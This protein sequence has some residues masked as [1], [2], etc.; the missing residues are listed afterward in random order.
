MRILLAGRGPKIVEISSW[1]ASKNRRLYVVTPDDLNP[2]QLPPHTRHIR[3]DPSTIDL[4]REGVPLDAD[5]VVIV[6][7]NDP[8]ALRACITNLRRQVRTPDMAV[9]SEAHQL[10][11]EFPELLFRS[12]ANIYRQEFHDLLKR[13]NTRKKFQQMQAI[14]RNASR[15]LIL[16]WGNPDPDSIASSFALQHLLQEDARQILIASMGDI[17][18]PEN[19]A[20]VEFLRIP[21]VKYEPSL[22][23]PGTAVFTVDAQPSFFSD[24]QITFDVVIDHHPK[25][26][27]AACRIKDVRPNYG[28]TATIL[29]E[30]FLHSRR[31]I[32]RR[33]ATALFYGLKTDT[34][35]LTRNVSEADIR[36]FR[37]L[38]KYADENLI[39][40]IELSQMP[41]AVLENFGVAIA[42]R[43][44]VGSFLFSY[45][46]PLD[47]ADI[48]VYIADFFMRLSGINAVA[49]GCRLPEKIVV[50][51]RSDGFR[52]DVGKVAE[53]TLQPY[54]TAGG[55]RT[56]ARAELPI[57]NVQTEVPDLND[58]AV[59]RWLIQKLAA[60]VKPLKRLL[61]QST[62]Q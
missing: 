13:V 48:A 24:G 21:M 45:L 62:P 2:A 32:P 46:G 56:M 52:T 43:K 9:I 25:G 59:E 5:D 33:V 38:K 23:I 36:A 53:T 44:V 37:I 58:A 17:T 20:M 31:K 28:S 49:V 47:N 1:L 16:L 55:H 39:R 35:N 41:M 8:Q 42:A 34:N 29:T 57:P 18:R 54:G 40:T 11:R 30:Y 15:V 51:F 3:Q 27:P 4:K 60:A 22:L 14:A 26:I 50:I 6:I 7:E 61:E 12:E 19:Q 10:R